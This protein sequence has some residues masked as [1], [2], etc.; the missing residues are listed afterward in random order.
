VPGR[1]QP[2]ITF[3]VTGRRQN[4]RY[5]VRLTVPRNGGWRA[6][7]AVRSE[8]ER[9]LAAQDSEAIAGAHVE[10]ET[11]RGKDF[12]SLNIALTVSTPDVA[13]ALTTAWR[14]FRTAAGDDLLGWDTARAAAEI[15]PESRLR[16]APCPPRSPRTRAGAAPAGRTAPVS[17]AGRG[18]RGVSRKTAPASRSRRS[19]RSGPVRV[20]VDGDALQFADVVAAAPAGV[21]EPS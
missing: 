13:Q 16:A 5:T 17:A 11:R 6:W 8:F 10:S 19:T 9:R 3:R 21:I 1:R 18:C 15:R 7:G 12:V 20:P 4:I 2:G 14:V